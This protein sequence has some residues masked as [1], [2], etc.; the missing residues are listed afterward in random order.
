ML[1]KE[2][3]TLTC[4]SHSV[5]LVLP[6]HYF[7]ERNDD[8]VLR[9]PLITWSSSFDS[10]CYH[11]D[12]QNGAVLTHP[13]ICDLSWRFYRRVVAD[14]IHHRTTVKLHHNTQRRQETN[15]PFLNVNQVFEIHARG[16]LQNTLTFPPSLPFTYSRH[17]PGTSTYDVQVSSSCPPSP[18]KRLMLKFGTC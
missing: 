10:K 6:I 14:H 11:V 7:L 3:S 4:F 8:M 9:R 15:I 17:G 18:T 12:V 5:V 2:K 13:L 16:N 1:C